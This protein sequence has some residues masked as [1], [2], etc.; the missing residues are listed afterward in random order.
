MKRKTLLKG[1]HFYGAASGVIALVILQASGLTDFSFAELVWIVT[2]A[3]G[4]IA[5]NSW[6]LAQL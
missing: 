6:K 1:L 2:S 5:W 4:L 3:A